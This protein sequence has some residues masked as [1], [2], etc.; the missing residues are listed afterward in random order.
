MINSLKNYL[1]VDFDKIINGMINLI[2]KYKMKEEL[3]N[4]VN[5]K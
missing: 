1:E 4:I 2:N 3:K 5:E